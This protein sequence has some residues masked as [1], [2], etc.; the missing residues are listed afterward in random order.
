MTTATTAR[1][2]RSHSRRLVLGDGTG[3]VLAKFHGHLYTAGSEEQAQRLCEHP[4]CGREFVPVDDAAIQADAAHV[5]VSD[6]AAVEAA[7][8]EP[9]DFAT[10]TV[11]ELREFAADAGLEIAAKGNKADLVAALTASG[12]RPPGDG[13]D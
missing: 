10:H 13:G 5:E 8:V 4:D 6:F 11:A 9:Y 2:F 12:W 7:D 1:T 3:Q